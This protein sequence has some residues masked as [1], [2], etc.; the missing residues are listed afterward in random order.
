MNWINISILFILVLQWVYNYIVQRAKN[1]ADIQQNA[2]KEY[3][4]EKGKNLATKEDIHE[5]TRAMEAVKSEISL[6]N[7]WKKDHINLR[8]QRLIELLRY[9][10]LIDMSYHKIVVMSKSEYNASR[11]FELIDELSNDMLEVTHLGN[12][13]IVDNN[14]IKDL[15]PIST[16]VTTLNKY[17]LELVTLA[18]NIAVSHKAIISLTD[19]AMKKYG[20]Q[21]ALDSLRNVVKVQNTIKKFIEAPLQF[22]DAS[23]NAIKSYTIWLSNMYK[24]DILIDY[25]MRGQNFTA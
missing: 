22:K 8:E 13:I 12:L 23:N 15:M 10:E 3:Q 19:N 5:I 21:E 4:A 18:N 11:L 24:S 20:S 25:P 14:N 7:Q 6:A 2:S 9:A 16:L 17:A 1:V